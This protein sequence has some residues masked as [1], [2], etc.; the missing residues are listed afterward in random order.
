MSSDVFVVTGSEVGHFS[1]LKIVRMQKRF[2]VESLADSGF[3]CNF[4]NEFRR[5]VD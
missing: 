1:G 4:A 2:F 5:V 3:C